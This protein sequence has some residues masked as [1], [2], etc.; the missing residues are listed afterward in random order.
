MNQA[1][2]RAAGGAVRKSSRRQFIGRGLSGLILGTTFTKKMAHGSARLAELEAGQAVVDISPPLGVELAGFHRPPENPRVVTGIRQ[3]LAARALAIRFGGWSAAIVSLDIAGLSQWM[4]DRV[5]QRIAE[6]T[7]IPPAHVHLVATHTHS[8]PTFYPFL[9]WGAVSEPYQA[10]VENKLVEVVCRAVEDLAPAALYL[11]KS[12]APG[13]SFNR[14]SP[15]YKTENEFTEQASDEDRWLDRAVHVLRL[16]RTGGKPDLVWYHFSCHP[17]CFRDSLAGPDWPGLVETLWK[18]HQAAGAGT[19]PSYLQGHAGDVNPGDGSS[20]IG[21]AEKTAEIVYKAVADAVASARRV[22]P[23]EVAAITRFVSLPL[24]WQIF[25]QWIAAYENDPNACRSGHWVDAGFA[26]AWY[27][28]AKRQD[29]SKD[30]LA[31][32]L[33]ALRIGGVAFLFHPSELYSFYGLAIRHRSPVPTTLVVGY[34]NHFIGYLTDPKAYEKGEY[35]ALTVPK[36]LGL[37]PFAAH[38]GGELTRASVEL[39]QSVSSPVG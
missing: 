25:D 9:Q 20:F 31:V 22:R 16:E 17:V 13:A 38:A 15:Q 4:T 36:I 32:E 26:A 10:E 6:K 35:A 30:H 37:P 12:L 34:A 21:P 29:R 33:A 11:G 19:I 1:F 7:G 8:A 18:D 24:D 2:S 27:A 28:G 23:D 3:P 39:L 14:T 5:R